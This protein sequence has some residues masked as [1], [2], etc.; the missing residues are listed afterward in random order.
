MLENSDVLYL[1]GSKTLA[2]SPPSRFYITTAIDYPNGDP[3]IGHA[4]EKVVVDCYARWYRLLGSEVF[5]VTGTDENGQ[6][7]TKAAEKA[8]VPTPAFIEE[9]VVK[10]KKLCADLQLSYTDFLRTTEKR[11][12][13][14]TQDLWKRLKANG[15]IYLDRY[16]GNYCIACET[17][18]SDAQTKEGKCPVHETPLTFME[19]VGY[20]FK[21]SRYQD[22]IIS[23]IE[24]HQKFLFPSNVRNEI[25]SRLKGEKIIDLSISRPNQGWGIPVPDDD[26]HVIYTW[27]DALISYLSATLIDDKGEKRQGTPWWPASVHVI[28][29][30]ITWFHSV[31]WPSMLKSAGYALPE[32]VYV[33]GMILGS[34]GKRM[35]KSLGNGVDPQECLRQYHVD[36][37]R[38]YLLKVIPSGQDGAFVTG[39][40]IRTH[41]AELA[42]EYGNLLNR[43]VKLSIA[44]LGNVIT[45]STKIDFKLDIFN[46][47]SQAMNDREHNKAIAAIWTGVRKLNAYINDEAPWKK[48]DDKEGLTRVMYTALLNMNHVTTLLTPFIPSSIERA[49]QMLGGQG[50]TKDALDLK[51]IDFHLQD[52]GAL[53]PRIDVPK[54]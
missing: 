27:F 16:S 48:K 45:P 20:F 26:K 33:H 50:S 39:D 44:N 30:D 31:I 8:G 38:Y 29:K 9:N 51:S 22:W 34:D 42:N 24:N 1:Q 5:L 37:F 19:E 35:S 46:E 36:S 7:L 12:V 47:V 23:H 3:H 6:K 21:L 53:F 54:S 41:N 15:D 13:E 43:V 10:F 28:G 40:L 49:L 18:Y 52:I 11:H 2:Q 4:Y 25:L 17:F 14:I 32:Q